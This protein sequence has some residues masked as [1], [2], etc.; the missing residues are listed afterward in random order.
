MKP[1]EAI[2]ELVKKWENISPGYDN[3]NIEFQDD[4]TFISDLTAVIS[5]HYVE[6][7]KYIAL[8][9]TLARTEAALLRA[10]EQNPFPNRPNPRDV[11]PYDSKAIKRSRKR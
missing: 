9:N 10:R 4:S 3:P 8:E 11:N 1:S 2:K 5:E 7:A 6:K